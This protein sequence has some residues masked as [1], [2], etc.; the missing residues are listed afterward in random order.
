MSDAPLKDGDRVAELGD[1][2]WVWT[3]LW[4]VYFVI[5]LM[6]PFCCFLLPKYK[7]NWGARVIDHTICS[8]ASDSSRHTR[9]EPR[10]CCIFDPCPCSPLPLCRR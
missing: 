3:G 9:Y 1:L 7:T 6:S 5:A 4:V 2:V 10:L 8:S